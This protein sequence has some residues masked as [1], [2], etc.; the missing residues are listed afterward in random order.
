M[1]GAIFC[2]TKPLWGHLHRATKPFQVAIAPVAPVNVEP[3]QGSTARLG[4]S[5]ATR[6]TLTCSIIIITKSFS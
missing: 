6:M 2:S 1:Y 3:C 4:K 5:C